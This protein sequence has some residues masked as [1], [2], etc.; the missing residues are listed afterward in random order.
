VALGTIAGPVQ[1][2]VTAGSASATFNLATIV[3]S[4]GIQK[5]SGDGQSAVTNTSFTSPLV[6]EVTGS[7]G[8]GVAGA[9]V[10]FQVTAGS[11]TVTSPSGTSDANG[12]VSTTVQ[13]GST[14]GPLTITATTAN[15]S[16][17]FT[18]IVRLP[19]PTNLAIVNG[20]SFQS[21]NGISPGGIAVVTGLGLLPGVE[22]LVSANNIVGP[23]PTTLQGV[24]ITFNGVAAPI[25]YVM[26]SGGVEQ[27]AVQVPFETLPVG[28]TTVTNVSVVV[29]ASSGS[30]A[31]ITVPVK[32]FAP[33]IFSTT[34]GGVTYAVAQRPDGTYVSPTNPAQLGENITVYVTG[35]G[36][37]TPATATGAAGI[38][39]Q[40]VVAPLLIGLNNSGVPLISANYVQG[41]TGVYA[42][43]LHV[44]ANNATG[45]AQPL[46]VIAYDSA[47]NLY[48]SQGIKIPVQ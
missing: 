35:L 38:P 7:G 8:S 19:G 11:G 46:A 41:L 29:T 18:L 33:G 13:A 43:T 15:F 26:N 27:V 31:T 14:P 42:V 32:P 45:S 2:M 9:I 12:Q 17:T 4:S 22:G 23:L 24:S 48:F 10:T 21:N 16:V 6:V 36:Q 34:N 39:G 20:A 37:V 44:P 28:T 3:P 1:V 30:P 47:G 5:V 40:V 25:Y